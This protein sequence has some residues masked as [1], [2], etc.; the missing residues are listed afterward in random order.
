M[1]REEDAKH[2]I[3][4]WIIIL[5]MTSKRD[6]VDKNSKTNKIICLILE[7]ATCSLKCRR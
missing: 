6:M 5:I 7:I 4:G 2:Y 3:F 1:R